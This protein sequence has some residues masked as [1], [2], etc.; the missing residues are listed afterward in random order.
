MAQQERFIEP[1]LLQPLVVILKS[2]T[3]KQVAFTF[4]DL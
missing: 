1:K 4:F 3:S 2:P